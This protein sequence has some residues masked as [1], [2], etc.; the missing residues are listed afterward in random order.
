NR[1]VLPALNR[2]RR[3]LG[4]AP[5]RS[6]VEFVPQTLTLAYDAAIAAPPG[7]LESAWKRYGAGT[8]NVVQP[9]ALIAD[10]APLDDELARFVDACDKDGVPCV[11]VG[12]GSM[13]DHSPAQTL[14]LVDATCSALGARAVLLSSGVAS[15]ERVHVVART[16]HRSLFPRM[17]AVVH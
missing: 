5:Y 11:Y 4:L 1:V 13:P 17:R 9:G 6:I 10:A 15:T 7:D 2:E 12:F 16:S 14:A 8:H 3:G